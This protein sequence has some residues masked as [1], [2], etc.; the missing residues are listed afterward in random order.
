MEYCRLGRSGL[1]ISKIV[2]GIMN[3]CNTPNKDESM[4]IIDR[5]IDAGI[6]LFDCSDIYA[7]GH[8]E[9]TFTQKNLFIPTKN[10]GVM[11][12]MTHHEQ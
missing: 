5:A 2:L 3:F 1:N 4:E 9:K 7:A 8:N 10:F 11:K 6:N 12:K